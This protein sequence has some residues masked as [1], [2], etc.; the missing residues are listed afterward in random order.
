MTILK[1]GL[2]MTVNSLANIQSTV[3]EQLNGFATCVCKY[4]GYCNSAK[5]DTEQS[6]HIS[7][8][9]DQKIQVGQN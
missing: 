5:E 7:K 1:A 4:V 3:T 8:V 6:V 9:F 2:H